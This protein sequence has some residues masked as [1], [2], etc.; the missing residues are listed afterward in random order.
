MVANGAAA[1]L[2]RQFGGNVRFANNLNIRA[3]PQTFAP[4]PGTWELRGGTL[5]VTDLNAGFGSP[6]DGRIIQTGG[7]CTVNGTL[8]LG[9]GPQ[10]Q[11][12]PLGGRYELHNGTLTSNHTILGG[13][14][15]TPING[16]GL[17]IVD[18]PT[19]SWT[20]S[21]FLAVGGSESIGTLQIS[22]GGDVSALG[23]ISIPSGEGTGTITV[24][25]G[26]D[27]HRR[28]HQ[29]QHWT[30]LGQRRLDVFSGARRVHVDEQWRTGVDHHRHP[31]SHP[32]G[33][34]R[35]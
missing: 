28:R 18:S 35:R 33:H 29:H 10:N 8:T 30:G 12:N 1:G 11:P 4:C 6:S 16:V 21:T 5:I 34:R 14:G 17:M 24:G 22:N 32:L 20:N 27:P 9:Q 25:R 2:V 15:S 23:S 13:S 26:L 19:A 7:A 3:F 31:R